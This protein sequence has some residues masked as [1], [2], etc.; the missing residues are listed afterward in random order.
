MIPPP[1]GARLAL[2]LLSD[3]AM[4]RLN[5]RFRG[6]RCTTDVLAFPGGAEHAPDGSLQ[7]GDIAISVPR[8]LR[9]ARE[10]GHPLARELRILALHGYLHLLGFDHETDRGE[11]SRLQARLVDRLLPSS[12]GTR[13]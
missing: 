6:K 13:S 2:C 9:Q 11:M 1:R 7:W 3:A 4:R 8:A 10:V 12:R 5:A